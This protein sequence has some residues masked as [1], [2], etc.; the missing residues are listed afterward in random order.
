MCNLL[1]VTPCRPPCCPSKPA[2]S[3]QPGWLK[4]VTVLWTAGSG[5]N[6]WHSGYFAKAE[7]KIKQ[8]A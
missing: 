8:V 6:K 1:A 7:K 5:K 2:T 3:A 4:A